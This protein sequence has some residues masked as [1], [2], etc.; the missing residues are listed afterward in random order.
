MNLTK[1]AIN[2]KII[3]F[4]ILFIVLFAGF[5]AYKNMPRAEDPGF[6]IRTAVVTTIWPGATPER[7]ELLIT[8]K[9]EK[10]IQEIPEIDF[11]NSTSQTGLSTIYVNILE[12]YKDMRPIWDNLRRKV[13]DS[14]LDLPQGIQGPFVDDEFGDMFGTILT[15]TGDG[16]EYTELKDI[17]DDVR[18]EL[19]LIKEVSKVD[20]YG[21][22]E[23]RI[24]VEYNNSRLAEF[25]L[26]PIQL[27]NILRER[28][29]VIPGGD[30]DTEYEKIALE[31]SGNFESLNDLKKT[32]IALPNSKELIYLEDLVDIYR[33]YMDPPQILMR[34]NGKNCLGL[35]ISMREGGNILN[36]GNNIKATVNSLQNIY[37]I[38]LDF[39]FVQ[40][41]AEPVNKKVNQFTSNLSQA[42]LIVTLVVLLFLGFRTGL[43]VATLIP[44]TIAAAFMFMGFLNIGLDQIS[45]A[46][47]IIALGMLVDNGI[48]MSESILVQVEKGADKISAA[49]NSTK[50]LSIALLI[51]SLTTAAAFLAIFLAESSVGEYTAPLFKVVTITLL[52]SWIV[53]I[54]L[55]PL[56][57]TMFIKVRKDKDLGFNSKFYVRYRKLLLTSLKRPKMVLI[58]VVF[59]FI[60]AIIGFSKVPVIFFPPSDRPT[61]TL[62]VYMPTGT[63]IERTNMVMGKIESYLNEFRI[64][65]SDN[66]EGI[67]NW[68]SFIGQGA[69]RFH[70]G[71]F[72]EPTS[73]EYGIMIVNTTNRD[74]IDEIISSIELFCLSNFPD[75]KPIIR[76]LELGPPAWP[77]FEVRISGNDPE[78]LFRINAEVKKKLESIKG[79][80]LIDDDW[81]PKSKKFLVN[82]NQPRALRAGLTSQDIAISLQTSQDG[83]ETTEFREDD[84]LIPVLMRSVAEDRYDISKLE[85]L[86]IFSQSTGRT[87]PLKQVADIDIAWDISKIQR[88]DRIKTITIESGIEDGFTANELAVEMAPWLND[89][90]KTWGKGYTWEFGGSNE[91]SVKANKS[92]NDKLPIVGIV[93]ILLL[94]G[95]FNSIR[96]PLII[97]ITI[98][99][100]IIGV[101]VG[102]LITKL[103]FGFMTLLGI[104][105]LSGIVINNAIVLID[106][107]NIEIKVNKLEPSK[108]IIESAQQRLRPILL[109]TATT[110]SGLIPLWLFGG[111]IFKPM[112]VAI[113]FGL[114]F[115]TFLTLLVIPILYSLFFRISYKD[116]N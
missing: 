74:V 73:P 57:C 59:L 98:P 42:V 81:G 23:E 21:A 17:A 88:R 78:E 92:I 60:S 66:E 110:I 44:T 25:G 94:V 69:P 6:I 75:I 103:Y 54:T 76:P 10:K 28:N 65:N 85:S 62:E 47:L 51:S 27:Q 71:F 8:D 104:I 50:E 49:L 1:Y 77:P 3:T 107:I 12:S 91:S 109:T 68:A 20:I 16:F 95:Q 52:C 43:I 45:L 9:I 106:R 102:L 116:Y 105:S 55:I 37:P 87:I 61:F 112:A 96:K 4:T 53:S 30:L 70:L 79:S 31:P 22:Q 38:G 2:K 29:I 83:L 40:F 46:A 97:L 32:I 100:G 84:K 114:L 33:G 5:S 19:L 80:K 39:D 41:Q 90:Q 15:I 64:D 111:P 35:A 58:I 26:S 11:I 89:Q 34:C 18:N 13:E 67:V 36:L 86:N 56:L 113:I 7:V 14:E 24:F 99:L 48:V 101:V 115:A 93:I 72:P 63:P 108:A 82:V